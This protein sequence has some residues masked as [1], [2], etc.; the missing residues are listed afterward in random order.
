MYNCDKLFHTDLL[1]MYLAYNN[2]LVLRI[3]KLNKGT[4][5]RY[6]ISKK[7]LQSVL[8]HNFEI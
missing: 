1:S 5:M 3:M 4:Y 6:N 7:L 2:M 8:V